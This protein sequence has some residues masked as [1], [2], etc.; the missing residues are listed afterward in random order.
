MH[1]VS[2]SDHFRAELRAR[3][4]RDHAFERVTPA[5]AALLVID[6]QDAFVAPGGVL[7]VAAARGIVTNINRLA[8]ALRRL[9]AGVIW[10]RCTF[11]PAGRGAWQTYF[12]HFAPGGDPER[13]RAAMYA[14]GP[15]HAFWSG[16]DRRAGEAVVDKDRFSAFIQGA[17][18]LERLLRE[19]HVDTVVISGTVT[20]VCCESTA[21]D[22]MMLDFRPV[23]VEDAC[24][25]RNDEEHLAG[26][27]TVARVFGDVRTTD[28]TIAWLERNRAA[29]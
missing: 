12:E 7:E 8:L 18:D 14:G 27:L 15:G 13:V 11:T 2:L 25:A 22:A 5:H 23:L 19:R 24:A 3:R 4:G 9:G 6:M 16:L 17:S 26:L 10:V 21:R 28:D 1:S 29:A 20:N